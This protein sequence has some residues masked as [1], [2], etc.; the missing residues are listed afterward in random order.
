LAAGEADLEVVMLRFLSGAADDDLE[1]DAE[2]VEAAGREE[3]LLI[4]LKKSVEDA[5]VD[6]FECV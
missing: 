2:D 5:I 6:A 1:L 4:A 3:D